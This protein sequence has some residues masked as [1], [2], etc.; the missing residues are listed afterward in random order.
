MSPGLLEHLERIVDRRDRGGSALLL[1]DYDGTLTPIVAHPALARL[2]PAARGMLAGLTACPG[3]RVGVVSGRALDDLMECVGLPGLDYAGTGGLELSVGGV[4]L[5]HPEA[6]KVA[7]LL[8]SLAGRL[9]P[10]SREYPGVWLEGKP[11]GMTIHYRAVAPERM[12]ACRGFVGGL[13]APWANDLRIVDSTMAV[14]ITPDL[15]WTKGSVVR[16]LY[17]RIKRP[18]GLLY[19]GDSRGDAEALA[20]VDALGGIAIGVGPEAP[21]AARFRVPDPAALLEAIKPLLDRL[22]GPV[23]LEETR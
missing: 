10:V 21:E 14:E 23:R 6:V 12:E 1:F 8:E 13:L 22:R 5:V 16:M 2:S 18:A 7:P 3:V 17:D 9:A 19:A 11:F 15:C 20:A 4:R